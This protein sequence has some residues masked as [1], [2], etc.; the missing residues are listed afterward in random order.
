MTLI[1]DSAIIRHTCNTS[2][3]DMHGLNAFHSLIDS[4]NLNGIGFLDFTTCCRKNLSYKKLSRSPIHNLFLGK[5]NALAA[6]KFLLKHC[7]NKHF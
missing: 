1:V 6:F 4:S 5:T 3:I 7:R 2:A